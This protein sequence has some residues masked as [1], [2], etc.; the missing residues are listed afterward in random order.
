MV[1][2]TTPTKKESNHKVGKGKGEK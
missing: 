1:D 2:I